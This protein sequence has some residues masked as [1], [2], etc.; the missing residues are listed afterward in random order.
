MLIGYEAVPF[1]RNGLKCIAGFRTAEG[2]PRSVMEAMASG[3]ACVVSNIRGN[4]DLIEDGKGGYS[5]I[6]LK[7]AYPY[8]EK[9]R[10]L[11]PAA[12]IDRIYKA[13]FV[14]D[15]AINKFLHSCFC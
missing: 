11:Y 8:P 4:V 1:F 12:L 3:L 13:L 10:I 15:K 7:T 9:Y 6:G 14:R 2:L 5:C